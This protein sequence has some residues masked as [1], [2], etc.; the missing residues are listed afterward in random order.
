VIPACA[1]DLVG[2]FV[3][4]EG[5]I[6]TAYAAYHVDSLAAYEEYRARLRE[7]PLGRANL[8][9]AQRERFLVKEDRIFLRLAST[10]HAPRV[11]P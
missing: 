9:V 6:T 11:T 7:H 10:P 1:A 2:Y 8:E 4:H 5:S 3:P